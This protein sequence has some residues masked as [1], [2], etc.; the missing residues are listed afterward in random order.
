MPVTVSASTWTPVPPGDDKAPTASNVPAATVHQERLRA[1]VISAS[2]YCLG[3]LL[4]PRLVTDHRL[5]SPWSAMVA[6][7]S[8]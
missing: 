6:M 4:A 3:S 2:F 7:V 8:E 5:R 1:A